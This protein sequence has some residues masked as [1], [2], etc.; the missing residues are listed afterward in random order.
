MSSTAASDAGSGFADAE[1]AT[2][3]GRHATLARNTPAEG[4]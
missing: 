4:R 1:Q 3:A 2:A